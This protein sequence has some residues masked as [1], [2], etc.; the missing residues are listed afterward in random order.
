MDSS[1]SFSSNFNVTYKKACNRIGLLSKTR[2][3]LATK[4][5][6]N[7]YKMM[8]VPLV[9][10]AATT[11]LNYNKHQLEKLLSLERKA[12]KV[13]NCEERLP[14]IQNQI[15]KESCLL[16]RK[17]ID[18]SVCENFQSYFKVNEH[19]IA[20]R[21]NGKSVTMPAVK[22]GYA[23]NSFYFMGSK[24]YNN[25]PLTVRSAENYESFKTS[26]KDYYSC[27]MHLT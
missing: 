22:L 5:A 12:Q 17:C 11:S 15:V 3:Y 27:L 25:L 1:L 10:Y 23:K 26:L 16:V 6:S 24:L 8:I 13:V 14:K 4:A 18:G 2:E 21:N 20:K 7:I 9:T 19:S